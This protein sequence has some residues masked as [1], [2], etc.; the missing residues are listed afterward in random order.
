VL[1]HFDA[2]AAALQIR[3]PWRID[4]Q[5][6]HGWDSRRSANI[7]PHER[8]SGIFGSRPKFYLHVSAT[9]VTEPRNR[10][11]PGERALTARN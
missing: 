7:V 5:R 10:S 1:D 6:G 11:W 8:D 2:S 4:A 9:E 3:A